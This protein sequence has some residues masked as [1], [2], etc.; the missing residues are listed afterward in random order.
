MS[1]DPE[2]IERCAKCN[3]VRYT[4]GPLVDGLCVYCTPNPDRDLALRIV[5][6]SADTLYHFSPP[7]YTRAILYLWRALNGKL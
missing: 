5:E 3:A 1:V 2:F 6:K 4:C 7:E